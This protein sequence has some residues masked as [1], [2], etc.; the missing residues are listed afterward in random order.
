L[1]NIRGAK[2]NEDGEVVT[3]G[4]LG[5]DQVFEGRRYIWGPGDAMDLPD[6]IANWM[7]RKLNDVDRNE[8]M[9]KAK[10]GE[11]PD[12]PWVRALPVPE[13]ASNDISQGVVRANVR[14][15]KATAAAAPAKP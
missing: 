8:A 7:I 4:T 14:A 10:R 9:K 5:I 13:G 15:K 3:P 12:G 2:L 6:A 11:P 1:E